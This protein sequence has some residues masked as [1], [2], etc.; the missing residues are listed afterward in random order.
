[1]AKAKLYQSEKWLRTRYVDQRKTIQE[2]A[3][4]CGSSYNTVRMKLIEFGMLR[5]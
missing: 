5:K 4:E 1:M 3:K 2:I